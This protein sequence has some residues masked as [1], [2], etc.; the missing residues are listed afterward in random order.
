MSPWSQDDPTTLDRA[1]RVIRGGGVLLYP[2]ATVY[3]LGCHPER[4]ESVARIREVKGRDAESPLLVLTDDWRRVESW[5]EVCSEAQGRLM[6]KI[7]PLA[8]T[9]LFEVEDHVLPAVRGSSSSLGIRATGHGFCR[10]LVDWAGTPIVSTSANPTGRSAPRRFEEID[11]EL[12]EAVDGAVE[13]AGA[14]G[15]EAST[16]VR[17]AEG[18]PEIVRE[19]AVSRAEIEAVI[20]E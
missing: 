12:L 2:T 15:G 19:G 3:G 8:V 16:V 20:R 7:P 13:A 4:A 6:E 10:G 18:E 1:A 9:I 5:I 14:P 17:F 11:P